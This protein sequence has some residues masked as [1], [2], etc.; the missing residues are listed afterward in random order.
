M[1]SR[2]AIAVLFVLA[3]SYA[4]SAQKAVRVTFVKGATSKTVS[5][6]MSGYKSERVYVVRVKAGQTLKVEQASNSHGVTITIEDPNGEDVSDME[7]S[8]NSRKS[9]SPTVK[10]DY[11]ITVTEC[12]K[13][14]A[15]RGTYRVRFAV[16]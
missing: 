11:R 1:L 10:G 12:M 9:V 8:C 16:R 7:A 13:A 3:F 2:L 6:Q 4:A 5:G 14:D 15:W